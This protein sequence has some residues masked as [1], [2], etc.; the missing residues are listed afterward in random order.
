[1]PKTMPAA[2]I[3]SI[4]SYA[5]HRAASRPPIYLRIRSSKT[6]IVGGCTLAIFTD[7][8]L[9]GIVRKSYRGRY[10]ITDFL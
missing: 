9:Y 4:V 5:Y 7:S 2:L 10:L 3:K 8:F 6:F 1:M